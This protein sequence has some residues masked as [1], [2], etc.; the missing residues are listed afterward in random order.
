MANWRGV[1]LLSHLRKAVPNLF[2]IGNLL[3]G[4]FSITF[5][6]SGFFQLSAL[7]IFLSAILFNAWWSALCSNQL[8]VMLL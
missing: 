7:F 3:S 4:V 5:N 1:A 2:T 8:R 6:M